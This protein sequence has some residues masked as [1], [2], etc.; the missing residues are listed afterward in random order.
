[1]DKVEIIEMTIKNR[2]DEASDP[3]LNFGQTV[4]CNTIDLVH[5]MLGS[6]ASGYQRQLGPQVKAFKSSQG[7]SPDRLCWFYLVTPKMCLHSNASDLGT[8]A[9]ISVK[10]VS[11][12]KLRSSETAQIVPVPRVKK[13]NFPFCSLLPVEHSGT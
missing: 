12:D 4:I 8:Q 13:N 11:S 7:R 9:R 5:L 2:S 10:I 3:V 1:L 6:D